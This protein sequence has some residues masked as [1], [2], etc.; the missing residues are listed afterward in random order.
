MTI[1]HSLVAVVR[2]KKNK[3]KYRI[4]EK[5]VNHLLCAKELYKQHVKGHW[6]TLNNVP[7]QSKS[8]VVDLNLT[9]SDKEPAQ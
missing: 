1:D 9:S 8:V 3:T 4:V 6:Q 7:Y 2:M 5:G